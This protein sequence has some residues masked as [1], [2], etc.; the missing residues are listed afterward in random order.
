MPAAADFGQ[1]T[2]FRVGPVFDESFRIQVDIVQIRIAA[3]QGLG[4]MGVDD[5]GTLCFFIGFL[6][7]GIVPADTDAEGIRYILGHTEDA[8]AAVGISILLLGGFDLTLITGSV[9]QLLEKDVG[10]VHGEG[11]PVILDQVLRQN[12]IKEL[13]GGMAQD[14][15]GGFLM[16]IFRKGLTAGEIDAGFRVLGEA[17]AGHIIQQ[18]GN[19]L[20]QFGNGGGLLQNPL[21]LMGLA[22][23]GE[24]LEQD[25]NDEQEYQRHHTQYEEPMILQELGKGDLAGG[26]HIGRQGGVHFA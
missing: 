3:S 5:A 2:G 17:A 15:L 23:G 16:S 1:L 6:R 13:L 8:Q 10:L 20:L 14:L 24:A 4:D 9:R 25:K 18:G 21:L 11:H 7:G 12:G 19:G 22:L 26:T